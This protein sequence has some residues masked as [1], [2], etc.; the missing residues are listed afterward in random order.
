MTSDQLQ[1]LLDAADVGD[2][3]D[4]EPLRRLWD[5]TGDID[6]QR[7]DE[8]LEAIALLGESEGDLALRAGQWSVDL[9]ATAVRTTVLTA[10]VGSVL[11]TQGL[12]EFAI[13]FATAILP[14]VIEIERIQL[15]AGDRR[16][17]VD[18]RAKR[19]LGSEDELYAALPDDVRE[20]VNRYD[21]ADFIE[22]LRQVG[23]A[24]GPEGGAIRISGPRISSG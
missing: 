8:F 21:F 10:L 5:L 1:P 19:D 7:F 14:T 20:Q 24:D 3:V 6:P 4:L 22:R 13:G 17:L 12:G 23:L 2:I 16:L 9:R 18:L 15:G 11:A